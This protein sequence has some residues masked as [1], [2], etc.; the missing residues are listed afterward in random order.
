M[1][2]MIQT[3]SGLCITNQISKPIPGSSLPSKQS[4][5][6]SLICLAGIVFEPSEQLYFPSGASY[7]DSYIGSIPR[8]PFAALQ[9]RVGASRGINSMIIT[10]LQAAILADLFGRCF[11]IFV[12]N[13][14]RI[15]SIESLFYK[16][17]RA[18][19]YLIK[20]ELYMRDSCSEGYEKYAIC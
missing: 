11:L 10:P 5:K 15:K 9:G 12:V 2:E 7:L 3:L 4:Q 1:S 14:I 20:I 19:L 16:L 8:I 13:L 18:F 6:A 17:S